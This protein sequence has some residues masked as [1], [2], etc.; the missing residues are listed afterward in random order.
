MKFFAPPRAGGE[1]FQKK[2]QRKKGLKVLKIFNKIYYI[3]NKFK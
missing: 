2:K 3:I 1:K